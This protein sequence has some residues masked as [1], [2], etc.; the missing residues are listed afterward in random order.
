MVK[1]VRFAHTVLSALKSGR[2][3]RSVL[4]LSG[5]GVCPWRRTCVVFDPLDPSAVRVGCQA[6]LNYIVGVRKEVGGVEQNLFERAV[7]LREE[8]EAEA[9]AIRLKGESPLQNKA[10]REAMKLDLEL[11]K[12]LFGKKYGSKQQITVKRDREED[13]IIINQEVQKAKKKDK[14]KGGDDGEEGAQSGD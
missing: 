6:R 3:S 4:G 7:M 11:A 1:D 5:C 13:F 12:Y 9:L 8:L 10:F 14:G 2:Y